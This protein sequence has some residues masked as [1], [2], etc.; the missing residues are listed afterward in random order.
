[1]QQAGCRALVFVRF[2]RPLHRTTNPSEAIIDLCN[3]QTKQ[4]NGRGRQLFES[5]YSIVTQ[6][7]A[8]DLLA[9]RRRRTGDPFH[10]KV[11]EHATCF[12]P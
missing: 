1:M 5:A 4:V 11:S 3:W 6:L 2:A 9:L 12:S 7:G 8:G 10:K